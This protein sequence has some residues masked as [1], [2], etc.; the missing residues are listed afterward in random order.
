MEELSHS[1]TSERFVVCRLFGN[2]EILVG[3]IE[4]RYV[5]VVEILAIMDHTIHGGDLYTQSWAK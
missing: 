1:G 4:A 5:S 2:P 3:D